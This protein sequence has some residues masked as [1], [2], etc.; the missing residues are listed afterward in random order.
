[1]KSFGQQLH[2]QFTDPTTA[3]KPETKSRR[4]VA[5]DPLLESELAPLPYPTPLADRERPYVKILEDRDTA[6]LFI[7]QANSTLASELYHLQSQNSRMEEEHS[8]MSQFVLDEEAEAEELMDLVA[9][10]SVQIRTLAQDLEEVM[11]SERYHLWDHSRGSISKTKPTL[12]AVL[13]GVSG[14]TLKDCLTVDRPAVQPYRNRL[15]ETAPESS[16]GRS[17]KMRGGVGYEDVIPESSE[18]G[19]GGM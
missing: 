3:N 16:N 13:Q 14:R 19:M 15:V 12:P 9:E 1:M 6:K 11:G 17:S 8:I 5:S 2:T 10:N 4:V 18:V 7:L